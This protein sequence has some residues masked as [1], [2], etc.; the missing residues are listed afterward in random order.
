[1]PPSPYPA[2]APALFVGVIVRG[3]DYQGSGRLLS[4]PTIFPCHDSIVPTTLLP[5]THYS[6]VPLFD[7][8]AISGHSGHRG[9]Y[10]SVR[11]LRIDPQA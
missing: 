1:M 6:E 8:K 7:H 9:Y 4:P 2:T 11:A 10:V 3:Y 5:L